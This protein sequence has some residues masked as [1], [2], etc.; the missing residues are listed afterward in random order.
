MQSTYRICSLSLMYTIFHTTQNGSVCYTN[1][2]Y[3][4]FCIKYDNSG[5]RKRYI[6]RNQK[7]E[8]KKYFHSI[9]QAYLNINF[10]LNGENNQLGAEYTYL[11]LLFRM[12]TRR[13]NSEE[14]ISVLNLLL[15]FSALF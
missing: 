15:E 10:S 9:F 3:V 12:N 2:K 8:S 4:L 7:I 1:T 5:L 14:N 6:Y 11:T 13:L